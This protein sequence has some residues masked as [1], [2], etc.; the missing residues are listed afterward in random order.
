MSDSTHF[1]QTAYTQA[2]FRT[3]LDCMARPGKVGSLLTVAEV[4]SSPFDTYLFGVA[5]T[6]LDHE[7]V[8]HVYSD[9]CSLS[10]HLQA[11]TMARVGDVEECDYLF[12]GRGESPDFSRLKR[13]SWQY[14]DES[15]TIIQLVEELGEVTDGLEQAL[16]LE[17]CGPGIQRSRTVAVRGLSCEL[18][19]SWRHCNREFPLGLDWILVD[20]GGQVCCLPRTVQFTVEVV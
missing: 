18:L 13:G 4:A 10:S 14:P 1:D 8:F 17:L 5:L 2:T 11:H 15:A 6:L 9:Q 7:V 16:R 3:L 19:Q 20:K 12:V